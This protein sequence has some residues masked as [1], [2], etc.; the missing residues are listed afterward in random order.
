MLYKNTT[1]KK[2]N[3]PTKYNCHCY[4][5]KCLKCIHFVS[6]NKRGVYKTYCRLNRYRQSTA[7]EHILKS[8]RML[9]FNN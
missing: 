8:I 4:C 6:E 9:I 5:S 2:Q 1:K 3:M 7:I